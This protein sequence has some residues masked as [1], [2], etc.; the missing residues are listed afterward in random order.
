[1]RGRTSKRHKLTV[2]RNHRPFAFQHVRFRHRR[3]EI[4]SKRVH[5]LQRQPCAAPQQACSTRSNAIPSSTSDPQLRTRSP[6]RRES[7]RRRPRQGERTEDVQLGN[8]GG[9]RIDDVAPTGNDAAA[10]LEVAAR[11][12]MRRCGRKNGRG[13]L[14]SHVLHH[15]PC[16]S[17]QGTWSTEKTRVSLSAYGYHMRL[18]IP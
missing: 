6:T 14:G 8:G 9:D 1:M 7:Q 11:K 2:Q 13:V 16:F 4:R 15:S 18:V 5:D 10:G 3:L 12:R 17:D